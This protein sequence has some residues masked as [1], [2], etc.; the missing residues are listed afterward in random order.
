MKLK[1]LILSAVFG[2]VL[3]SPAFAHIGAGDH[4]SFA[5]GLLHPISGLDH[6]LAMIAV[7]FI[8]ARTGPRA[9]LL[10]PL[11]FLAMM[12]AGSVLGFQ[13]A[14]LPLV[15]FGIATSVVVL[16][17]MIAT[18]LKMP[19]AATAALVGSFAILHGSSHGVEMP[20]GSSPALYAFGFLASTVLLHVG[21]IGFGSIL[22]RVWVTR[23]IGTAI[24]LAGIGLVVQ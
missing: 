2:S 9:M 4:G 7:G 18:G 23:I 21:G 24:S 10:L 16:G 8:A 20:V 3:A 15:E 6:L 5:Q 14:T 19:V 11:V 13:R 17:L 12:T 1:L 22:G